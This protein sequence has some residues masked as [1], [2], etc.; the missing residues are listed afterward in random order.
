MRFI[1]SIPSPESRGHRRTLTSLSPTDVDVVEGTWPAIMLL[2]RD[3]LSLTTL[4]LDSVTESDQYIES[5]EPT[6][7]VQDQSR[8]RGAINRRTLGLKIHDIDIDDFE[9]DSESGTLA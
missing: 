7:Y 3:E 9:T 2:V 4:W 8:I 5:F 6:L 1:G